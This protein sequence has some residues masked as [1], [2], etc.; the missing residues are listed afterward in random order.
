MNSWIDNKYRDY[1]GEVVVYNLIPNTTYEYKYKKECN[2]DATYT[3]K[4]SEIWTFTT[5]PSSNKKKYFK[6]ISK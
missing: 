1:L 2:Y 5:D 6:N 3:S 4:W